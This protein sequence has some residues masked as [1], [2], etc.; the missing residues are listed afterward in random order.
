M[1]ALHL[2]VLHLAVLHLVVL[3]IMKV[4]VSV[5]ILLYILHPI[6]QFVIVGED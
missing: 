2:A 6:I 5:S 1:V 4:G 3:H